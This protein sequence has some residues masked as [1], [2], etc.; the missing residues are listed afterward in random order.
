MTDIALRHAEGTA[1]IAACFP[2]MRELRPHLRSAEELIERVSR[3]RQ[4]AGYRILAAWSGDI[5]NADQFSATTLEATGRR[6]TASRWNVYRPH[7]TMRAVP[8]M[9]HRSGICPNTT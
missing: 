5:A 8:T 7:V 9:L 2:V 1:Q 3:Q 4:D 6:R